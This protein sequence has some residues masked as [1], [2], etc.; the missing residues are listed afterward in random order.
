MV[1][2]L[3]TGASGFIGRALVAALR[4]DGLAVRGA[5]R[6]AAPADIDA[7][8]V[9]A[10]GRETDWR[11]ALEDVDTVVHLASPAHARFDEQALRE[12]IVDGTSALVDQA[13]KAGVK[14]F[15]QISSIK[16]IAMRTEGTQAV[17][18]GQAPE[19][20]DAY[21]RAKL[22]AEAIALAHA[23]LNPIVLRPPL[24]HGP[25]AKAN[26]ALLLRLAASPTPLPFAHVRNRRSVLAL[27]SFVDAVR[28]VVRRPDGPNGV[29][30][31]ADQPA[32]S[33]A[34]MIA[35]LRRGLGRPPGLFR[36]TLLAALAPA[37]LRESLAVDDS[38]F[39]AA[40]GEIGAQDS[41]ALLSETARAW[42]ARA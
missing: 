12:A 7:A 32:L 35:A 6:G 15:I 5:Y 39:R 21:G 4:A 20:A 41:A 38:A 14:R 18:E 23:E 10:L 2:V 27:S 8:P 25:E 3:I 30:H 40:Y 31:L 36:A 28:A 24:V 34:E 19:P 29:F 26:F 37:V 9:G 22:A 33:T 11:A 42:M 16:A 13:Q 17:R 1:R